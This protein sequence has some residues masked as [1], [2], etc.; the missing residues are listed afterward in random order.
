MEGF[1]EKK[2]KYLLGGWQRRYFAY[3]RQTELHYWEE[4]RLCDEDKPSSGFI[5]LKEINKNGVQVLET[6]VVTLSVGARW[7]VLF[8]ICQFCVLLLLMSRIFSLKCADNVEATLWVNN[9][10]EWISYFSKF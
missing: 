1:M 3:R 5:S 7:I 9:I 6:N 4:K 2:S 10:S 8:V